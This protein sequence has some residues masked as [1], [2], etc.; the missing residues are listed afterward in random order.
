MMMKRKNNV[1]K[2]IEKYLKQNGYDGLYNT[3]EDCDC[4]IDDGLGPCGQFNV[5]CIPGGK[6]RCNCGGNH[7]YHIT[8]RKR[9]HNKK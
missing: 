3:I 2:I 1:Y 8:N 6:H 7:D 9:R 4:S 5:C